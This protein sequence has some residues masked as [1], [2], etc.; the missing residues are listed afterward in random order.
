LD[1]RRTE[2][3]DP[4][5]TAT[6]NERLRA[7]ADVSLGRI[8]D[9]LGGPMGAFVTDDFLIKSAKLSVDALGYGA[10]PDRG[11]AVNV[12]VVIQVPQKAASAREWVES[13]GAAA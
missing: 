5:L 2:I 9:K 12:A 11:A 1:K 3:E 4:V 8:L 7:L 6:V 13:H 10:R